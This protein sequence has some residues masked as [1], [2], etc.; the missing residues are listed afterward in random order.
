M[1]LSPQPRDGSFPRRGGLDRRPPQVEGKN[2]RQGPHLSFST[3]SQLSKVPFPF[4]SSP[5]FGG[6]AQRLFLFFSLS[7]SS[8][9]IFL[10]LP[11]TSEDAKKLFPP[12]HVDQGHTLS[13][14]S[15]AEYIVELGRPSF[16]IPVP[17]WPALAQGKGSPTAPPSGLRWIGGFFHSFSCFSA[18]T[19]HRNNC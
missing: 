14:S 8:G 10:S 6:E 4:Q 17:G 5:N 11:G 13:F 1:L 18:L 16:F 15:K 3:I 19:R 7:R 2:D 12:F 9:L